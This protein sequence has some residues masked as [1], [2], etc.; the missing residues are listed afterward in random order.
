[1]FGYF[2]VV[3]TFIRGIIRTPVRVDT[4]VM[5]PLH[6]G[7]RL[8]GPGCGPASIVLNLSLT[9]GAVIFNDYLSSRLEL[10]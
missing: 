2:Y 9:R 4:T 6:I 8:D 1:M 5:I 3:N 10:V 7:N